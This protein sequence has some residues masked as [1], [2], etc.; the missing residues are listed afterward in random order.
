MT[1]ATV[2]ISDALSDFAL[3][4]VKGLTNEYVPP[5]FE[6]FDPDGS[7]TQTYAMYVLIP[8]ESIR[9]G[10][11]TLVRQPQGSNTF[12]LGVYPRRL[13][14]SGFSQF[15]RAELHCRS[16]ALAS[17][18]TWVFDSKLARKAS[19]PPYLQSGRR[20]TGMVRN[21]VLMI[22]D[23]IRTTRTP[24]HGAYGSEWTLLEAVQRLPRQH[25]RTLSYTLIKQFAT[26][27]P[28]HTL[29]YRDLV[30]IDLKD[31]PLK[32]HSYCDIGSG[33]IPTTYWVDEHNR[34]VF[35][36]S[37]LQVYA[38]TAVNGLTGQCPQRYVSSHRP[39]PGGG[40]AAPP[41]NRRNA[42]HAQK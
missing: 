29:A 10:E 2:T 20:F 11:F 4:G 17:P 26:P 25:T 41:A 23:N 21:G 16:D 24:L 39:P 5:P 32:L 31:G 12:T 9:V 19:D 22:R 6:R 35:V 7:W 3:S 30:T 28:F 15:E 18:V 33:V 1:K 37:G 36:C 27:E 14:V 8:R 38:L 34:L 40:I 42:N 13:S